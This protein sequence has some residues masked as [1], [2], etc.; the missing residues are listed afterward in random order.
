MLE[1]NIEKVLVIGNGFDLKLGYK[2]KYT[3]F[4]SWCSKESGFNIADHL[5]YENYRFY[6]LSSGNLFEEDEVKH[7]LWN[8]IKAN[9]SLNDDQW[10]IKSPNL[11]VTY[12]QLVNLMGIK[13]G[14]WIDLE[15]LIH[16]TSRFSIDAINNKRPLEN[17]TDF[18]NFYAI[19]KSEL[20][21]DFQIDEWVIEREFMRMKKL[22]SYWIES[23]D[24]MELVKSYNITEDFNTFSS[25]DYS[26]IISFNYTN[27]VFRNDNVHY[28]HGHI[29]FREN[30]IF[31]GYDKYSMKTSTGS[32]FLQNVHNFKLTKKHQLLSYKS[33]K[34]V[35]GNN[36]PL[37]MKADEYHF[38]GLGLGK[39]DYYYVHTLL[40]N[41]P[42]VKL[43]FYWYSF[44]TGDVDC[45]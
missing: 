10:S 34:G 31:G 9:I 4:L 24:N 44:V 43:V 32:P 20:L 38:V 25:R 8:R 16:E 22:I 18:Y 21:F 41:N 15:E 30:I 23:L 11:W 7:M 19:L 29:D 12:F 1:D 26:E 28:I 42:K 3:D 6:I 37:N 39:N 13:G 36:Q 17:N 40:Q 14:N 27:S 33:L 2:S 35:A 45:L 5:H